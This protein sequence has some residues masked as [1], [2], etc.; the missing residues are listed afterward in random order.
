MGRQDV[1]LA[2]LEFFGGGG[3]AGTMPTL[4]LGTLV[5]RPSSTVTD[6]YGYRSV[7]I[8]Q[9]LMLPLSDTPAIVLSM[10]DSS[11]SRKVPNAAPTAN[12]KTIEY[13]A[14]V[15]LAASL[16]GD[17]QTLSV[18]AD[19]LWTFYGWIDQVSSMIRGGPNGLNTAKSL[20][21]PSYP[22]GG[23]V[24][25]WGE[26]F[27]TRLDYVPQEQSVLATASFAIRCAEWVNA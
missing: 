25:M 13:T 26:Q 1:L 9:S 5:Y 3:E 8:S 15:R 18:G 17:P 7:Y 6:T 2:E 19:A 11:E 27:T 14:L 10:L 23:Q 22:T 20:I 16:Q 12:R 21:T 4:P 24:I